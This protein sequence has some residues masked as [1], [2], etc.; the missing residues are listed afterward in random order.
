[1]HPPDRELSR[2]APRRRTP[3]RMLRLARRMAAVLAFAAP[4]IT[5]AAQ[6]ASWAG[7]LALSEERGA[8]PPMWFWGVRR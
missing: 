4:A 6:T 3:I 7:Y 1:M 5:F 2:L 8:G